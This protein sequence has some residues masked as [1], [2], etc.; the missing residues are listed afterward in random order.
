M[1]GETYSAVMH[2]VR[3]LFPVLMFLTLSLAGCMG[4]PSDDDF[5]DASDG[6][7][8]STSSMPLTSQVIALAVPGERPT[9]KVGDWWEFKTTAEDGATLS[10]TEVVTSDTGDAYTLTAATEETALYDSIFDI[11]YIGRIRK[12]DLSGNQ[13]GNAVKFFEWPLKDGASWTARWDG[14]VVTLTAR[15]EPNVPS[16]AGAGP[17]Y[18]VTGTVDGDEFVTYTYSPA[19]KWWTNI[20]WAGGYSR[21]L[22]RVGEN[23]TG[24]VFEAEAVKPVDKEITSA[25]A[26]RESFTVA[27]S[28]THL[29]YSYAFV[30]FQGA[31]SVLVV[32]PESSVTTIASGACNPCLSRDFGYLTV[33][34]GEW[35]VA[36]AHATES[37]FGHLQVYAITL[38]S[39]VYPS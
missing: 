3:K 32:D 37:G 11:S 30:A 18:R 21:E 15:E 8:G 26:G 36:S 14:E 28:V 10:S 12:S 31:E 5:A 22:V 20:K 34:P 33:K 19:V 4:D 38:T 35:Q 16:P 7:Q 25:G 1:K 6:T 17:G 9:W 23:F 39:R 27:E 13:Q 2:D 24:T 29:A